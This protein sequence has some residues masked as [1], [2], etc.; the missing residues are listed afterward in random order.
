ML[1]GRI[2]NNKVEGVFLVIV[3]AYLLWLMLRH[4]RFPKIQPRRVL[5]AGG[6]W[7]LLQRD[8]SPNRDFTASPAMRRWGWLG[9]IFFGIV[10]IILDA[11]F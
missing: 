2:G 4:R 6:P 7:T 10:F 9:L 5:E 8:F 11:V 3:A 1:D